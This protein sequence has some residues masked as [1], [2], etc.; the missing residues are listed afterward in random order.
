MEDAWTG[1]EGYRQELFGCSAS[2]KKRRGGSNAE[3]LQL[4]NKSALDRVMLLSL[5]R[6]EPPNQRSKKLVPTLKD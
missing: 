1:I 5:S 6:S 4:K 2:R 3:L